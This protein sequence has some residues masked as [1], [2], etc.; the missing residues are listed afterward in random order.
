M[1]CPRQDS[2][3]SHLFRSWD[4]GLPRR[5]HQGSVT[6]VATATGAGATRPR[7]TRGPPAVLVEDAS[8]LG[9]RALAATTPGI[10]LCFTYARL[11]TRSA[12]VPPR[13]G[14][15]SVSD[16]LEGPAG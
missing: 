12:V 4:S 14:P 10:P 2:N 11:A 15:R 13:R 16:E 3:L 7:R 5:W 9:W 6:A 1:T 8:A